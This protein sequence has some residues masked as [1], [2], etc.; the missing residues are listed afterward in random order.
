LQEL[1]ETLASQFGLRIKI[2]IF[3]PLEFSLGGSLSFRFTGC[4]FW[5]QCRDVEWVCAAE[6]G[7]SRSSER[8]GLP[9]LPVD[10]S[11]N[12][13]PEMELPP[14]KPK[15][16]LHIGVSPLDYLSSKE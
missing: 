16:P 6:D 4:R 10:G 5:R 2:S 14:N 13:G 1:S 3:L 7:F 15:R 12:G 8:I 9:D 11:V